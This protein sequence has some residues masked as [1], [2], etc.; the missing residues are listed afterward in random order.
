[1]IKF[2][3]YVSVVMPRVIKHLQIILTFIRNFILKEAKESK[4]KVLI[5]AKEDNQPN[6]HLIYLRQ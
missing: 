5:A 4:T 1:M 6:W 2:S 3:H